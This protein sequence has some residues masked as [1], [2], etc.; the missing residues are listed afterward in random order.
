[1]STLAMRAPWLGHAAT[2]AT[3]STAAMSSTVVYDNGR[4]YA[5]IDTMPLW[6]GEVGNQPPFSCVMTYRYNTEAVDEKWRGAV[7]LLK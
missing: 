4:I 7:N 6:V 1:M 5:V 2:A 3:A